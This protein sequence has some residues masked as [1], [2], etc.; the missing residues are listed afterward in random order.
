MKIFREL[1]LFFK[2]LWASPLFLILI[3]A[4]YVFCEWY[5]VSQGPPS[6]LAGQLPLV[7]LGV[8]FFFVP[9]YLLA[10]L[11]P[12]V[13]GGCAIFLKEYRKRLLWSLLLAPLWFFLCVA[14]IQGGWAIEKTLLKRAT[15]R[16]Q[17]LID[18]VEAYRF[19]NGIPPDN[20]QKLVPDYLPSIPRTGMRENPKI[21]YQGPT[22]DKYPD[23]EYFLRFEVPTPILFI[24]DMVYWPS[25]RYEEEW[26]RMGVWAYRTLYGLP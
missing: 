7:K 6:E 2:I 26:E 14:P 24:S 9:F 19:D 25:Q 3:G 18:A 23:E 20:L 5:P 11:Y 12:L 15:V 21:T 10:F 13:G 22:S 1:P 4:A 17:P 16:L 8:A